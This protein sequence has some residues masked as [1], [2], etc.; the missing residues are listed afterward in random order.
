[1]IRLRDWP[2]PI[3]TGAPWTSPTIVAATRSSSWQPEC[4][5]CQ[6]LADDL[7]RWE[8][9]PPRE[10]CLACSWSRRGRWRRT[11]RRAAILRGPRLGLRAGEGVRCT[12][13]PLSRPRRCRRANRL[14]GRRRRAGCPRPCRRGG[15]RAQGQQRTAEYVS[16]PAGRRT[17]AAAARAAVCFALRQEGGAAHFSC[18]G[19]DLERARRGRT[20]RCASEVAGPVAPSPVGRVECPLGLAIMAHGAHTRAND[21]TALAQLR[22]RLPPGWRPSGVPSR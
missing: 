9:E 7:R 17:I 21:P 3:S 12:R 11:D 1:M 16:R 19:V 14:D 8:A 6:R 15:L 18:L 5:H 2:G 22:E 20:L 4:P 13:N 10:G